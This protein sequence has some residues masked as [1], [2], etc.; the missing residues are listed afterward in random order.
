MENRES[1]D[2][3]DAIETLAN[4]YTIEACNEAKAQKLEIFTISFGNDVPSSVKDM[5]E[6]CATTPDKFF[7]A[8]SSADLK[9]AFEGIANQM[10]NV[11]LSQ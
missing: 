2:E 5:L 1:K 11:R 6:A 4:Q 10:L 3:Q 7:N 8:K 9:L